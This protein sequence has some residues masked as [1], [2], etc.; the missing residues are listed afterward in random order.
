L[1]GLPGNPVSSLVGFLLFIKPALAAL[2]GRPSPDAGSPPAR[3]ARGFRHRGDRPSYHPA[4]LVP[5]GDPCRLSAIE[6]LDWFGSADLRTAATADGFAVF[7]A[8]DRDYAPGEIVGFLPT[9]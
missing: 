3:L 7:P 1:V 9:R 4:R 6:T 8:G 2:T 5:G